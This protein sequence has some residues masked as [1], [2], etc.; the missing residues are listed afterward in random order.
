[1]TLFTIYGTVIVVYLPLYI[2]L[3]S[4]PESATF[5]TLVKCISKIDSAMGSQLASRPRKDVARNLLA[6]ARVMRR[7]RPLIPL[8]LDRRIVSQ[9]AIRASQALRQFVYPII[10]RTDEDLKHVKEALA[11][12]AI[13]IGTTNWVQVGGPA[14]S[15]TAKPVQPRVGFSSLLPFLVGVVV[16]LTAALMTA[17]IRS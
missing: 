15:P 13:S 11:R 14:S 9:E 2:V 10:L 3:R 16:P 4:S 12:P 8:R 6:C 17:L 7:Y 1:V 5:G